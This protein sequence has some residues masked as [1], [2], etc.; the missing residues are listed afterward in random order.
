MKTIIFSHLTRLFAFLFFRPKVPYFRKTQNPLLSC[1]ALLVHVLDLY[2]YLSKWKKI[3]HEQFSGY[4]HVADILMSSLMIITVLRFSSSPD[5]SSNPVLDLGFPT[6]GAVR[7]KC[8]LYK[9]PGLGYCCLSKKPFLNPCVSMLYAWMITMNIPLALGM[10]ISLIQPEAILLNEKHNSLFPL[11]LELWRYKL[12]LPPQGRFAQEWTN[13]E[14]NSIKTYKTR[15]WY[16]S[17]DPSVVEAFSV[18]S[19]SKSQFIVKPLS[20]LLLGNQKSPD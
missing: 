4:L 9:P 6:C 14:K 19:T 3:K 1:W 20:V 8:L 12:L 5:S 11:G 7:S 17:L 13:I 2:F 15:C 10:D 16:K 18:V